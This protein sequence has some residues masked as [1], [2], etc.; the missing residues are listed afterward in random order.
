MIYGILGRFASFRRPGAF[1]I[2]GLPELE[3]VPFYDTLSGW[4]KKNWA[5]RSIRKTLLY[6]FAHF[7][8]KMKKEIDEGTAP[9]SWGRGV[10]TERLR[11]T[12]N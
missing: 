12:W 8:N 7:R 9:H 5:I 2:D 4:E 6:I 3:N 11:E 1:L 10:C